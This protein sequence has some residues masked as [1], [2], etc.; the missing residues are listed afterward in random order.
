M[1]NKQNLFEPTLRYLNKLS[2]IQI[3]YFYRMIQ[4]KR[5]KNK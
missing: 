5:I 1:I 2:I 4:D 3:K